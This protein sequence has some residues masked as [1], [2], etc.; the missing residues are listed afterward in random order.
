MSPDSQE[1]RRFP[2]IAADLPVRF[3]VSES[4]QMDARICRLSRAGFE[5]RCDRWSSQQLM[6]VSR[7]R[8]TGRSIA[9]PMSVTV[10][11]H[12]G[13]TVFDLPAYVIASRRISEDAYHVVME[14]AGLNADAE[15][16]LHG[17]I[18]EAFEAD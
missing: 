1:R 12:D 15:N 4:E 13:E 3:P 9:V 14:Y 16:R 6:S 11:Q 10:P 17:Y 7:H 2:R 5:I 18:N 8:Q